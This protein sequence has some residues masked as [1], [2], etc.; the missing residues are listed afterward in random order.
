MT[1]DNYKSAFLDLEEHGDVVV[2]KLT[3]ATLNDEENIE[4]LGHEMFA[5][6]DQYDRDRV[7][8]DLAGVEYMTSS[9]IGKIIALH[10]RLQRGKGQ[11][12]LCNLG[13]TVRET[14]TTASLLRYF[15]VAEDVDS[16]VASLADAD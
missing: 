9:A 11:L 1:F 16:A 3:R 8:L 15:Q 7:V 13:D 4:Q 10:R 2:V 12:V 6:V 5:I 14:F